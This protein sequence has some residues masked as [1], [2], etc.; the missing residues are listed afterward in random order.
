[1][2][3]FIAC[4][5]L[6]SKIPGKLEM[7]EQANMFAMNL[8]DEYESLKIASYL[9]SQPKIRDLVGDKMSK[10]KELETC[11]Q[12]NEK[13]LLKMMMDSLKYMKSDGSQN[14]TQ[15]GQVSASNGQVSAQ[16]SQVSAQNDQMSA[17]KFQNMNNLRNQNVQSSKPQNFNH[18]NT[19]FENQTTINQS[20]INSSFNS[21]INPFQNM[22][23]GHN[24][25]Q[26]LLRQNFNQIQHKATSVPQFQNTAKMQ[27]EFQHFQNRSVQVQKEIVPGQN[28]FI[29]TDINQY[30]INQTQK[31]KGLY[32]NNLTDS[33]ISHPS[34]V[35]PPGWPN[36]PTLPMQPKQ[37][38]YQRKLP[39]TNTGPNVKFSLPIYQPDANNNNNAI[40]RKMSQ[41]LQNNINTQPGS[42]NVPNPVF[43]L[44][45][46]RILS[47]KLPMEHESKNL[48]DDNKHN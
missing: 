4:Q 47:E 20:P 35:H 39:T 44:D 29:R 10:L 23:A 26:D 36:L 24:L 33:S 1:M 34:V 15:N 22:T 14:S 42:S 30:N 2:D 43:N 46:A 13:L 16:N 37:D 12:N 7:T 41:H 32:D 31:P 38:Q 40:A 17:P 5:L 18:L 27:Q 45:L 6:L 3:L 25:N 28:N 19:I 11:Q 48:A 21:S 8:T 9:H